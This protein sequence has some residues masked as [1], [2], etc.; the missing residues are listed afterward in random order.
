[1][2][3][4][5]AD[6]VRRSLGPTSWAAL[7]ILVAGAVEID[8]RQIVNASVR[9]VAD[10]LGISKN[11]VHR[12]IRRLVDNQL[13]APAQS[14]STD[15]RFLPGTYCLTVPADA[16]HRAT[17]EPASTT[18]ATT[19]TNRRTNHRTNSTRRQHTDDATQLSLLN[20]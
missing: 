4:G 19:R 5:G 14:R 7:E 9:N 16:L 20:P 11:A 12:A 2:V 6:A 15:G 13:V 18:R 17:E 8:E 1:V 10:A 3:G